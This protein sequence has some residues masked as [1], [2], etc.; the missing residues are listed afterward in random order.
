MFKPQTLVM[1]TGLFL[2]VVGVGLIVAQIWI[3]VDNPDFD[4]PSRSLDVGGAGAEASV[5]T[6]YPGV[7]LTVLG[8]V[9]EAVGFLATKPW[10]QTG[11]AP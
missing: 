11:P 5:Q 10:R 6:T 4:A 1:L 7:V 3:Q 8:V 2:I 9:L